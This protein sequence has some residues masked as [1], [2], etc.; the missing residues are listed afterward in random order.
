MIN[1]TDKEIEY[2]KGQV[3]EAYDMLHGNEEEKEIMKY[4]DDKDRE[5]IE[6]FYKD[7]TLFHKINTETYGHINKAMETFCLSVIGM[8]DLWLRAYSQDEVEDLTKD[9][10]YASIYEK[11]VNCDAE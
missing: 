11:L 2:L 1:F 5:I 10:T 3:K 6:G 7:E 8:A 4:L 9:K